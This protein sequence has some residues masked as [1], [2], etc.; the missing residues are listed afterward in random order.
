M[1][2]VCVSVSLRLL[3]AQ[4]LRQINPTYRIACDSYQGKPRNAFLLSIL[5]RTDL[6]MGT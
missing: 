6:D 3:D 1:K 4:Q 2:F 5:C